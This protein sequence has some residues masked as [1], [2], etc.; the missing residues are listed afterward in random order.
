MYYLNT[1]NKQ[2]PEFIPPLTTSLEIT[3]LIN[4]LKDSSPGLDGIHVKILKLSA[5]VLAPII[6]KL[7]NLSFS[8]GIFPDRLKIA[9]II[10]V[11]KGGEHEE[12]SNYRPISILNSISK[13]FERSMSNRLLEFLKLNNILSNCQF[14]FCKNSSPQLAITQLI[15]KILQDLAN[16]KYSVSIF[17]DLKKAFDTL[18]HN[19]LLEKLQY[20]GIKNVYHKWF[21]SYLSNRKQCTIINNSVSDFSNLITGVPQGSTLGPLLFLLYINDIVESSKILKFTLFADDTNI[22]H[23]DLDINNR[24]TT[25]NTELKLISTWLLSNKLSLNTDK[26]KYIVFTGNKII[27]NDI[28]IVI[29]NTKI[30][31]TS[32]MKYLGVYIDH[33]L[34]WRDHIDYVT[35]KISKSNGILHKIKHLLPKETL[36]TLYYTLIYPYI[37]YCIL[38]W[39]MAF[40]KTLNPL[41]IMQKRIIRLIEGAG[42]YAHTDP[43]FR[44]HG[45]LKVHDVYHLES[46]KFVHSQLQAD[47]LFSLTQASNIHTINTRHRTHL[48]PRFPRL[49]A[50][51]RFVTY[52]ACMK[53]NE[54]PDIMKQTNN[55]T[56]FKIKAKQYI[57]HSYV[58]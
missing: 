44:S 7:I 49:E 1:L 19:I 25:V 56:T 34:T 47:T 8:V 3:S 16:G 38:V 22:T 45:I 31:K 50:Q 54:L 41:V 53:W 17:L 57:L 35:N 6:S 5:T 55:K 24:A 9:K 21:T 43:L 33:K 46:L 23:S 48:R 4:G 36:T 20:Y 37:Q 28:E 40:N 52:Y 2:Y 14:G 39:G 58:T 11:F 51:R 27:T 18:D 32:T 13:I 29:C 30:A 26:T 42:Y 12:I 15:D 10:P